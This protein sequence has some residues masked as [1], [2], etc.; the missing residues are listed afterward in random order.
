MNA[1]DIVPTL[2]AIPAAAALLLALLPCTV[3]AAAVVGGGA[4]V[5]LLATTLVMLGAERGA[6]ELFLVDRLNLH[7]LVLTALIA[8]AT[9]PVSAGAIAREVEATRLSHRGGRLFHA[10]FQAFLAAAMLALAANNLVL[11]WIAVEA[12]VLACAAMFSLWR[13]P[14]SLAACW[15]LLVMCGAGLGLALLGTVLVYA[16]AQPATGAG[17]PALTWSRV[18]EV[19]AEADPA[20]LSLGFVPVLLGYGAVAG[21]APMNGWLARAHG[22]GAAPVGAVLSGLLLNVALLAMLRFKMLLAASSAGL[23]PGGLLIGLGLVSALAA[24]VML[25]RCRD[26]R[27]LLAFSSAQHMGLA[28]VAFGLGGTAGNVAGLL[29]VTLHALTKSALFA[30]LGPAGRDADR[31]GTEGRARAPGLRWAVLAGV[32]AVAGLPPFGLFAS[33]FLIVTA[34]AAHS[35]F[36]AAAVLLGLVA[37][38]VALA[39]RLPAAW[40]SESCAGRMVDGLAVVPVF[41]Q[42]GL[43]LLAGIWLPEPVAVWLR[44]LAEQLG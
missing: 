35:P 9:A 18:L 29:Q 4:C 19:S 38:L 3:R 28:T 43:V 21:L 25:H 40:A 44:S 30:A 2:L 41:M 16:A 14:R 20:L 31:R 33:A 34:A 10:L 11:L 6:G 27:H 5:A 17:M 42:L 8:A 39:A 15:S 13:T 12:A 24:V 23:K 26:M 36:L 37:A 22:Q 7:L 1:L 32:V